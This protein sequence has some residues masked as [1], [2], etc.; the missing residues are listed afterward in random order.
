MTSISVLI[1]TANRPAMLRTALL[2]VASQT[3][4]SAVEEVVVIENLGNRES[5]MVCQEFPQLPIRYVFRDPPI[6][7]GIAATRDAISRIRCK[8]MALLFDDDWWMEK[9]LENAIASLEMH[10]DAVACYAGCIWTTGEQGYLMGTYGSFLP[11]FAASKPMK[12]HRLAFSLADLLV[13]S[14]INTTF[15]YSSLVVDSD[16]FRSSIE[17]TSNGNPYD[18]DRLIP[19]ELSRHGAVVY[20]SRAQV[21]IRTHGGR[22]ATRVI[23]TGEADMWWRKS[24]EQLFELAEKMQINLKEEF[25]AR[26]KARSLS[27]GDLRNEFNPQSYRILVERNILEASLNPWASNPSDNSSLLRRA[28]REIAPP[29]SRKI[30]ARFKGK[31]SK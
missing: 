6:P 8:R 15:H 12:T 18:T 13:I 25:A 9:H 29:F 31:F 28:L 24:T 4:L 10:P 11:W 22:E 21:Y 19:V 30:F 17:C 1:P 5:G 27:V 2:S 26:M 16:V 3:A 23:A 7:P 14:Q 20:D